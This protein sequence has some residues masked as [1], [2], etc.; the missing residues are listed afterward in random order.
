MKLTLAE[1]TQPASSNQQQNESLHDVKSVHVDEEVQKQLD[2]PVEA[3]YKSRVPHEVDDNLK[4]PR[5]EI[6]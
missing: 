4:S 6:S 1:D 2:E 3:N 5:D